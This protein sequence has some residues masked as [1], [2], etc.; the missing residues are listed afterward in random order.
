MRK[1]EIVFLT[2]VFGFSGLFAVQSLTRAVPLLPWRVSQTP[3]FLGAA[4]QPREVDMERL[5]PLLES[6]AL[7]HHEAEFYKKAANTTQTP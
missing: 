4:G 6:G 5:E 7:S 3:E 2:C 1:S